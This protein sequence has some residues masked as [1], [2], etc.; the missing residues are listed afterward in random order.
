MNPRVMPEVDA[1]RAW[2]AR[3]AEIATRGLPRMLIDGGR[4]FCHR[5][6]RAGGGRLQLEGR[7]ERYTA[8]A[9]IGTVRWL[10]CGGTTA[11]DLAQLYDALAAWERPSPGDLGLVLWA[12]TERGDARAEA[13]ARALLQRRAEVFDPRTDFPSMEMGFLLRGLAAGVAAGLPGMAGFAGETAEVL[14]RNQHPGTG[15]FSFARRVRR[16]NFLRT[17]RDT[18]LG[19]F[20]SQVYPTMGLA[21]L[22]A[23]GG[24]TRWLAAAE[25]CADRVASLQGPQGQWWWIYLPAKAVPALRHPVYSVHQDAMGPMLLLATA[26]A[27]GQGRRYDRAVRASLDWFETRSECRGEELIDDAGGIVWRAVQHDD[28]RTTGLLGLGPRE[29][30]R[31]GRAAWFG[32]ADRRELAPGH[33]CPECRPYHLGW[34]LLAAAMWQQSLAGGEG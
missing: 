30:A 4:W 22:T 33:L 13:T 1:V 8:M 17:R 7:S 15:L 21:A 12:Q 5:A 25:R 9:L 6:L 2:F 29:L 20:A 27:S 23:A 32:T 34:I 14:L 28:P 31:L 3:F 16:K 18:R 11:L 10:G 19:S 24:E 26:L